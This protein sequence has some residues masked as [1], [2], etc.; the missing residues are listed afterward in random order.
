MALLLTRRTDEFIHFHLHPEA[1]ANA[2]LLEL[3]TKGIEI[4]IKEIKRR[5]VVTAIIAP[6]GV[7]VLRGELL[8]DRSDI[9]QPLRS[10]LGRWLRRRGKRL[11]QRFLRKSRKCVEITRPDSDESRR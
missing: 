3:A 4:H 1:N 5:S 10:S 9:R 11:I 6:L 8:A 7:T 2:L